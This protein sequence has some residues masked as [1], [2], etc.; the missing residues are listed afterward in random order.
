ML[1]LLKGIRFLCARF[2]GGGEL[3]VRS[4]PAQEKLAKSELSR[5]DPGF[6]RIS[7][8]FDFFS[9]CVLMFVVSRSSEHNAYTREHV[10]KRGYTASEPHYQ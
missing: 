9:S 8:I 7:S 3:P 1:A 5:A 4:R 2:S 6:S 10:P